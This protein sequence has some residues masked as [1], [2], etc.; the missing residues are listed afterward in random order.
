MTIGNVA[1]LSTAN[2]GHAA[3]AA[4]FFG[5]SLFPVLVTVAGIRLLNGKG[6]IWGSAALALLVLDVVLYRQ[7]FSSVQA[8][9]SLVVKAVLVVLIINGLRGA[10]A[11]QTMDSKET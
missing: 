3:A 7:D 11:L 2:K 10:L 1:T 5:A 6:L 9:T 4:W 8:V